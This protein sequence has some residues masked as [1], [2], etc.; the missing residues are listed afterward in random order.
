MFSPQKRLV[1]LAG[2]LIVAL[3]LG[4]ALSTA[5]EDSPTPWEAWASIDVATLGDDNSG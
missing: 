4:A 5:Q 3:L 1:Y 2:A